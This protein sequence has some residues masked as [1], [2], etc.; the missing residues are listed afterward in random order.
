[1]SLGL[2]PRQP[3]LFTTTTSFCE[4]RVAPDSI[5]GLL[6]REC[7]RLFPD[8][9][10]ADLFCDDGRRSV[11]PMIVAVVMVLQRLEGCSDR[12]AVERFTFDARWKYAAGGLD[13]DYPGFVHT[14]L[15][16]M[17]A[18]LAGSEDPKRIF[19]VTLDAAK[20]AGLVG[21]RRVLDSTPLYDAVATM[22]TVTLVRSAIR[23]LLAVCDAALEQKLRGVLERDDDYRSAGKAV[24]DWDDPQAREALIDAL[25]S[26]ALAL[27]VAL[28]GVNLEPEVGQAATLLAGVVGQDLDAGKDGVF[29]IARRVAKDRI[30]ST[31]D[32]DARHG[33]KTSARGF[34]GYKGHIAVDPDSELIT[35]TTVS[36][37]NAGDAA[38]VNK[39]LADDLQ[40]AAPQ[41]E[42]AD[43]EH[44]D[45]EH[46]DAG[47]AD[48]EQVD[49]AQRAARPA[50]AGPAAGASGPLSVYGDSA[51]G[52]G[53]V[54]D[55]LEQADAEIYT[56]TQPPTA[57]DG[58]FAKDKF[59]IDLD[60]ATVTCP[61]AH[62]VA[63]TGTG[64]RRVAKFAGLCAGCPLADQCTTSKRGRT[65]HVGAHEQQ[66]TRARERQQDPDWTA[67]YN[68][69]RPTV[70]RKIAHL[71][72]RKHGGRRAR[73]RG[74]PKVS[75]DFQLLAAAVNLAR[76][77]V[78]GLT[79][80]HGHWQATTT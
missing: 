44:A 25:A 7:H 6:H 18:R 24:C 49:T 29:R 54:L 79:G 64:R 46:A 11:P 3:D 66:L 35:A 8:E 58:R 37:G 30:I 63:L 20:R 43:T 42:H 15:V 51:Y 26:D 80:Q 16:D 61:A 57:P 53:E 67:E 9:M 34:D 10:F 55:T 12:E 62:T 19:N 59:T 22:D 28:E 70:E 38:A 31:V 40:P 73:V 77:A 39:L 71:T 60:A 23:G 2:S 27:L 68:A 17:R 56:K 76:L 78:L 33:H 1:M 41:A 47:Q 13:F 74:K 14:V 32:P 21:R 65:I 45:A 4:P 69:T 72:R 52:T 36:A 75:A 50:A 5:Y 48:A